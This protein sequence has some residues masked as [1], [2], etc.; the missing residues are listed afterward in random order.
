MKRFPDPVIEKIEGIHI[1]RDDLIE[2]GSKRRVV[3]R[4]IKGGKEF[5]YASTAY[6]YAQIALAVAC[7]DRGLK[8]TIFSAQR[9]EYTPL[10]QI[11]AAAGARFELVPMGYLSNVTAKAKAYV[12]RT[13]GAVL[14]PFG[15]ESPEF[16]EGLIEVAHS[17]KI[18]PK[19]VWTVSGSGTLSRA[20][21]IAWPQARFFAVQVGGVRDLGRARF[22]VAPEKF[23]RDAKILPPFPSC[24]NYDAK[25]WRF[26][27]EH[28]SPG[29]L[30]WNVAQ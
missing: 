13:R 29:A 22:F 15:F 9:K 5:V 7:R 30:F 6:G 17:I 28:A 16:T 27:R 26:I 11:A 14:M 23:D 24:S 19:E 3:D 12:A 25:A 4:L 10:M 8:A 20:L 2:G 1:L 21:Q 18:K